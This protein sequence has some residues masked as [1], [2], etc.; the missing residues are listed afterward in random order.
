MDSV[1]PLNSS[2]DYEIVMVRQRLN[3]RGELAAKYRARWIYYVGG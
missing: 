1:N 3:G 2:L